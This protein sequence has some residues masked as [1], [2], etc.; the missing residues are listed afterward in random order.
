MMSKAQ[1]SHRDIK[2]A[3]GEM[4]LWRMTYLIV[5]LEYTPLD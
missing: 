5:P 3:V 1:M 2:P 4:R